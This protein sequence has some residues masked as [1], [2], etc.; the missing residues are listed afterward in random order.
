MQG[1]ISGPIIATTMIAHPTAICEG[2][3]FH[4][5]ICQ[6]DAVNPSWSEAGMQQLPLSADP[7]ARTKRKVQA[8][9]LAIATGMLTRRRSRSAGLTG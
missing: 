9:R 2:G 3:F 1:H 4:K 5:S 6:D 7:P 8:A